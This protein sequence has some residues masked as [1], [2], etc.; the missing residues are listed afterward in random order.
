MPNTI[1]VDLL[2]KKEAKEQSDQDQDPCK[3][4]P[5]LRNLMLI[6]WL[7]LK[8]VTSDGLFAVIRRDRNFFSFF[9]A[10]CFFERS[11]AFVFAIVFPICHLLLFLLFVFV[12]LFWLSFFPC[13]RISHSYPT[14]ASKRFQS[15]HLSDP[16]PHPL[17]NHSTPPTAV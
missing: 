12:C 2:P 10:S 7:I 14:T 9:I 6:D 1:G 8:N 3:V 13:Y 5:G 15:I 11:I 16:P 4:R 17:L